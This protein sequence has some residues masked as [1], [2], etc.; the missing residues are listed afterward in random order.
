[1][2]Y[3]DQTG[4]LDRRQTGARLAWTCGMSMS[5]RW[6]LMHCTLHVVRLEMIVC[7]L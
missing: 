1:M 6:K 3:G 4:G 5:N 2:G 7:I